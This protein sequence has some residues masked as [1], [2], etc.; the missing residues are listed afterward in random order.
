[1]Q[2]PYGSRAE[3]APREADRPHHE[4]DGAGVGPTQG[5][6]R[7][8]GLSLLLDASFLGAKSR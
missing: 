1:V 6:L 4:D 2:E 8:G 3:V 7:P 5:P